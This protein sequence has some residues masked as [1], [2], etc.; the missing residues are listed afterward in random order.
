PLAELEASVLLPPEEM[1]RLLQI[2]RATL[3]RAVVQRDGTLEAQ[4]IL[5]NMTLSNRIQRISGA[6]V[7]LKKEGELRGCIG[8]VL[9]VK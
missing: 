8:H 5:R 1:S 9:P 3:H 7:T 6:F 4:D 2:A